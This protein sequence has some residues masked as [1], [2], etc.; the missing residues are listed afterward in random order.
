VFY[1][2][3]A[4]ICG[5][6]TCHDGQPELNPAWSKLPPLHLVSIGEEHVALLGRTPELRIAKLRVRGRDPAAKQFNVG[7]DLAPI[8]PGP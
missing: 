7:T 5:W 6:G 4:Q 8:L 3:L 2:R 1:V